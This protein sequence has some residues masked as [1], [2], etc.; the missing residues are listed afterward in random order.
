MVK[1]NL[2]DA[3][4]TLSGILLSVSIVGGLSY[5]NFIIFNIWYDIILFS[6]LIVIWLLYVYLNIEYPLKFNLDPFQ[7]ILIPAIPFLF[8][9]KHF[10]GYKKDN[11][12][13]PIIDFIFLFSFLFLPL[14][15][16]LELEELKGNV[17]INYI[18]Y[19]LTIMIGLSLFLLYIFLE[20]WNKLKNNKNL[21]NSLRGFSLFLLLTIPVGIFG[22]K[23]ILFWNP[24]IKYI[25]VFYY[26]LLIHWLYKTRNILIKNRNK[27]TP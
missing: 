20:E 16:N 24:I 26:I 9:A 18:P 2:S 11:Y 1:S 15:F 4:I 5:I 3:L 10:F 22:T 21:V 8:L 14:A 27:N 25:F 12:Y 13:R 23:A 19:V 6:F 7:I 17:T